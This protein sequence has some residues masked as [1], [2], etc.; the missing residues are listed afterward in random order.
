MRTGVN[1]DGK[2]G[3]RRADPTSSYIAMEKDHLESLARLKAAFQEL[4]GIGPRGAERIAFHV[5]RKPRDF[6]ASLA[7]A[8]LDVKDKII[9]CST[10]F[11]LSES[12]QCNI[13]GNSSRDQ[14]EVWVVE[15]PRDLMALETTGL[16]RGVYHVL[17]GHVTPLE[18]VGPEDLTIDALVK[19]VE[20][21]SIREVIL[22]LSPTLDG[23]GTALHVQ[24]LL[25]DMNVKI[26]RLA[27]GLAV[28]SQI[29]F[30]SVGM[31]ESAIR[32]R[33]PL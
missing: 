20:S 1:R 15:Q 24:S 8:L 32:G 25:S 33:A 11:N 22:A 16:V 29:E 14:G 13:C 17:M 31:L 3:V 28:G 30:A 12:D 9:H 26:T 2:R 23:D 19:R 18:G 5:L 7:G 21:G 4:P 10:C 6:A 27:R